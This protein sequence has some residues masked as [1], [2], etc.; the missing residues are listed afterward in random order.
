MTLANQFLTFKKEVV[1]TLLQKS[2][3]KVYLLFSVFVKFQFDATI[4]LV[5]LRTKNMAQ[6]QIDR[7]ETPYCRREDFYSFSDVQHFN[8]I[9]MRKCLNHDR[10]EFYV[11]WMKDHRP[12]GSVGTCF[13]SCHQRV[14]ASEL[15]LLIQIYE[16]IFNEIDTTHYLDM[17][18]RFAEELKNRRNTGSA[19]SPLLGSN[20]CRPI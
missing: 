12:S 18:P 14:S 20:N 17:L 9:L 6:A 13:G 1:F 11:H 15:K 7:A 19:R 10:G 2:I 4:F 5:A 8:G 16:Q 3:L